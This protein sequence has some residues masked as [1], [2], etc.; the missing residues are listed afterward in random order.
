M[1]SA[2]YGS[3]YTLLAVI[4]EAFGFST[5]QV[6]VIGG[7]GFLAGFLA[8]VG[9][10]RYADRGHTGALFFR[11]VQL[12]RRV[13]LSGVLFACS[14]LHFGLGRLLLGRRWFSCLSVLRLAALLG[15][16]I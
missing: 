1:L 7:A 5:A 16:W 6:G 11:R 9:L 4:R 14:C 12:L 13:Q 3:V 10:S 8:Q 15:V 2:G